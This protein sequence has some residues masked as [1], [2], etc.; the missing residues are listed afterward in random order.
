MRD[1]YT[2]LANHLKDIHFQLSTKVLGNK[3]HMPQWEIIELKGNLI[4]AEMAPLQSLI[5]TLEK[6]AGDVQQ[7]QPE[8]MLQGESNGE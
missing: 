4:V 7:Q 8:F 6:L 1:V 5:F 2:I 3:R